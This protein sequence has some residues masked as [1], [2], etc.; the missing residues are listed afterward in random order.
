MCVCV[1]VQ[2]THRIHFKAVLTMRHAFP[3]FI[4]IPILANFSPFVK[5]LFQF[6][7]STL[8]SRR[9]K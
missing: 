9:N 3:L 7:N 5:R 1:C 6:L 8:F 2:T 4:H